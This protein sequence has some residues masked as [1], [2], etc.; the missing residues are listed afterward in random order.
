[1]LT[2]LVLFIV[3]ALTTVLLSVAALGAGMTV[4]S[5][6]RTLD[7]LRPIEQ[8]V[9]AFALGFA[10][11]G[12]AVFWLGAGNL[13]STPTLL[14]L[15]AILAVPALV[16]LPRWMRRV[17]ERCPS[18]NPFNAITIAL[19]TGIGLAVSMDFIEALAPPTDADSLAYHFAL[20]KTFFEAGGLVFEPRAGDGAVPLM[21]QMT[22]LTAF[23]IGG[24][25]AMTLWAFVSGTFTGLAVYA[26]ARRIT[27]QTAGREAALFV[28]LVFL[29]TPAVILGGG[30]GQVEVRNALF[31]TVAVLLALRLHAGGHL[32]F[33]LCAGIA[34]GAFAA[35]KYPG[36]LA[37]LG[38]GLMVLLTKRW[39]AAGAVYAL[40]A[41]LIGTQ[42]Y[43]WNWL[44]TGDPV[45]PVLWSVVDYLPETKWSDALHASFL[46]G[47][48]NEKAVPVSPPWALLYPFKATFDPATVFEAG[49]VGMGVAWVLFAPLSMYALIWRGDKAIMKT[50][51]LILLP[52]LVY[53]LLWY[54]LGPSQRVRH[55]L[56]VYP[57]FLAVFTAP[58]IEA[59]IRRRWLRG[60]I[61]AGMAA[62]VLMQLGAQALFTKKPIAYAFS[63]QSR[64]SYLEANIAAY[65]VVRWLNANIGVNERVL[66]PYRQ[67]NY[68]L[69]V[70]YFYGHPSTQGMIFTEGDRTPIGA[71]WADIRAQNITYIASNMPQDGSQPNGDYAYYA[72][73][74]SNMGC[75]REVS[76]VNAR[77]I[78]SRTVPSEPANTWK[79]RI[80]RVTPQHCPIGK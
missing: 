38:F 53:Y 39:F 61:L 31:F 2:T 36:L 13:I 28:M 10:V 68:V 8:L 29:T 66:I 35:S 70:P 52:A 49:R 11:L 46:L 30:A 43:A 37:V 62:V 33:A 74:L 40:G 9:S 71:F 15:S 59:L 69:N 51:A 47:N 12:W 14:I 63:N 7:A 25:R 76:Q 75:A 73:A 67:W 55:M 4:L 1:M 3:P 23:G 57:L 20:A 54:F 34:A 60:P 42:W 27:G 6:T 16:F 78:S 45:F 41:I 5:V 56:P 44:H 64:G 58:A 22:Y 48:I 72:W 50:V 19:L 77:E 32:G 17:G 18:G 79:M 80:H 26:L 24:E 21:Q 65:N